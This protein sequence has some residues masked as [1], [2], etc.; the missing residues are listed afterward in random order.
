MWDNNR[1]AGCSCATSRE[2]NA[3][4]PARSNCHYG[5]DELLIGVT[6]ILDMATTGSETVCCLDETKTAQCLNALNLPP[7]IWLE[8]PVTSS[9]H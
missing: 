7:E 3:A 5:R 1:N 8:V 9:G 4:V 2:A 6:R